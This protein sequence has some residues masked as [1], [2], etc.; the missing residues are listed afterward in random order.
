MGKVKHVNIVFLCTVIIGI[1]AQFL[2]VLLKH[3]IHNIGVYT[4]IGQVLILIPTLIYLGVKN[5]NPY[6]YLR[7]HKISLGSILLL[8]IFGYLLIPITSFISMLSMTMVDNK[9]AESIQG[10][11]GQN[12]FFA[13]L[14]IMAIVPAVFEEIVYRGF[15]FREYR[16]QNVLRGMILSSLLFGCMHMNVNQFS[17]AFILGMVFV[18]VVEA[19]NSVVSTIILHFIL[20]GT[21][22]TITYLL[23]VMIRI[24]STMDEYAGMSEID[25]QNSISGNVLENIT[26]DFVFKN[27]GIS[28]LIATVLAVMV[29]IVLAKHN[30]RF[31]HIVSIFKRKESSEV[32][33]VEKQKLITIPLILGM[34]I[35]IG[36]MMYVE[37]I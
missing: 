15:F 1:A 34:I 13:G 28:T 16:E 7:F 5:I 32:A 12:T 4:L 31:E 27:Y 20:N 24:L 2:P 6:S 8:I 10:M 22:V 18:L 26:V 36:I 9:I 21:S 3:Y 19:T 37:I 33:V 25:I 35:C 11:V 17:Y 30:N 23:P 29:F 14:C